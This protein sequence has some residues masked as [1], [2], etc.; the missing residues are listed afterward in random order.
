M[1]ISPQAGLH[2]NVMA[3]DYDSEYANLIVNH[4]LSYETVTLDERRGERRRI[5]VQQQQ[6]Q[7]KEQ[8]F[9]EKRG[10]LPTIVERFLK[11]RLYFK[12]LLKRLPKENMEYVLV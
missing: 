2:E 12:K 1:I 7:Q 5:V 8:Q 4:N 3:L 11:R 10:L 9:N 6:Q